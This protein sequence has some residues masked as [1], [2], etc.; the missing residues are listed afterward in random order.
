MKV[1]VLGA[2]AWGTAISC[3]L[4]ARLEVSL[5]AR[6]PLQAQTIGTTRRNERY[7]PGFELPSAVAVTADLASATQ[8]ARLV[9][10]ATPVA[11]LRALLAQLGGALPVV[12]LCKGFEQGTGELPHQIA[13][14]TLGQ[15]ARFGALSGPS[16][17]EE[18]AR[19]LPCALTLA[20]RDAVFAREAAGMLHGGRMR[21]YYSTDLVG[22]EIGGAVKN[23][24]AIAA[25]LSDGMGLGLNARAA[26]LTRGLAEIA[27]LGAALGGQPETFMGLAGAGDL[28]LTATGDL[29]RNRRV[30]LELAR[31]RSLGEVMATLG[32]VAEGVYSAKEVAR[33]AAARGVDMPVTNAVNDVLAG[34]LSP[35]A[36]VERLL[37]RESKMER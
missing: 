16:F 37:A 5:W 1:A 32:H 13:A 29:S 21:V 27:R 26:L 18:V 12:W 2:G 7:L 36:A 11:G 20:S 25:G 19:G 4:A 33:L 15:S 34:R 28:I 6:D 22:V 35:A 8:G 23:I 17:A 3:V 31:G 10:A 14:A 24:M 30:G 9:L